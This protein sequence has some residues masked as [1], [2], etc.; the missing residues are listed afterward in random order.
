MIL[1]KKK[2]LSIA[3]SPEVLKVLPELFR[4]AEQYKDRK[5]EFDKK[6]NCP[7]CKLATFFDK[8][9]ET[10]MNA[11][12]GLSPASVEKLKKVL[13]TKEPLYLYSSTPDGIKMI[14]LGK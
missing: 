5:K 8:E 11:L 7:K 9:I 2:A 6:K 13:G 14:E 3:T 1:N 10:A 12:K 4:V